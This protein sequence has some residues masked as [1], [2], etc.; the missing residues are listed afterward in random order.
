L[1]SNVINSAL[2]ATW[3]KEVRRS[4]KLPFCNL[5]S[6]LMD[7]SQLPRVSFVNI[8]NYLIMVPI[9]LWRLYHMQST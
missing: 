9:L 2:H 4:V 5:Q 3:Y 6:K 7:G 1:I 8:G